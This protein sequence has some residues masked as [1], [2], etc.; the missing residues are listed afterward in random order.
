MTMTAQPFE[1]AGSGAATVTGM[2]PSAVVTS[3][4]SSTV[5]SS[6]V[7]LAEPAPV[8]DAGGVG[9]FHMQL[10]GD[11]QREHLRPLVLDDG[12][13][14]LDHLHVEVTELRVGHLQCIGTGHEWPEAALIG[15]HRLDGDKRRG[16]ALPR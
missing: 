10:G 1:V 3:V 7:D 4:C 8:L 12:P 2:T 11:V 9:D 5:P 14:L 15:R 16:Q 13:I 6:C